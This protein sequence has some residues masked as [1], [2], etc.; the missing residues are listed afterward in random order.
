MYQLVFSTRATYIALSFYSVFTVSIGVFNMIT[1]TGH[2]I[3][4]VIPISSGIAITSFLIYFHQDPKH[5]QPNVIKALVILNAYAFITPAWYFTVGAVWSSWA[6]I[7]E[8]PPVS[9][10]MLIASAALVVKAP[11]S[12]LR[13]VLITWGLVCTPIMVYLL[14]HSVELN[15]PRGREMLIFF[16]PGGFILLIILTYQRKLIARFSQVQDNLQRSRRQAEYDELTDICNRRGLISWLSRDE[17]KTPDVS[18]LIIDIDHFKYINDTHGHETG[19]AVLKHVSQVLG[20]HI[21]EQSCLARWGGDEFVILLKDMSAS[22][23]Q[24]V[25]DDCLNSIR[26]VLFP[27]VGHITCSIGAAPNLQSSD[28]DTIIRNADACLYTAKRQ[29]RN[30]VVIKQPQEPLTISQ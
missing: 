2:I 6:F 18:G 25:A 13:F 28:I 19:D 20:S 24:K 8:F 4:Y 22:D 27:S 10:I 9:G 30:Q 14:T 21:P 23:V 12:W 16:G 29:G 5:H 3:D 7:D 15:T 11:R 17:S 1:Q 26:E